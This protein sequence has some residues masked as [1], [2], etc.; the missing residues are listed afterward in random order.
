MA[1]R[2]WW[3]D[4]GPMLVLAGRNRN[5]RRHDTALLKRLFNAFLGDIGGEDGERLRAII[6][7]QVS[8]QYNTMTQKKLLVSPAFIDEQRERYAQ[9]GFAC[10]DIHDMARSSGNEPEPELSPYSSPSPF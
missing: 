6:P 10:I 7:F 4:P 3:D 9:A 5:A 1:F 8:L 2:G